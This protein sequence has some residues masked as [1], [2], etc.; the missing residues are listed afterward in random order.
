MLAWDTGAR[1]ALGVRAALLRSA[2]VDGLAAFGYL[3]VVALVVYVASWTGWLMHAHVYELNLARNNYGPYWGDYTRTEAHG[4]LPSLVQGLRSLWHYHSDVWSFHSGGLVD[5]THAYQSDPRT[6]L[7]MQRPVS[8]SADFGIEPGSQGCTAAADSTCLRVVLLLGTPVIWWAGC[9]ALLHA[10]YAWVARRDWR[11]GLVI[12]GLA[13]TWL[14]FW[15]YADRPIFSFYAITILPFTIIAI[16]LAL[17]RI[18]GPANAT[19][20]RRLVG[21]VVVGAFV[22][23]VV[24]DFGWLYPVYTGRLLTTAEWLHRIWFRSWI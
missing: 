5:A 12:V 15:R 24:L 14:P 10:A 3:V 2:V 16:C 1:R 4:F 19:A 22:V 20:R 6:W 18:L 8:V 23:L 7:I 9:A 17:G 13:T 21:A 11:Y